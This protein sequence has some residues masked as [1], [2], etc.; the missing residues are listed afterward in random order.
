MS[1]QNRYARVIHNPFSEYADVMER[2]MDRLL[3]WHVFN[4]KFSFQRKLT[5]LMQNNLVIVSLWLERKYKGYRYL[6][7]GNRKRLYVNAEKIVHGFDEFCHTFRVND[8]H[9]AAILKDMGFDMLGDRRERVLYLA[10]IM[11]F[12]APGKR[13]RYL[14]G[15]SFGKLLVDPEKG[16]MTG[17][18]NQIVTF[19]T[20][21]YSLK[22]DV[23]DLKIKLLLGHVCL[24]YEGID[25]EA[26]NGTFQKYGKYEHI[27][28]IVE[29]LTTNLLDVSDFRD[30]QL[31][32]DPR[33]MINAAELAYKISSLRDVVEKNLH[34]S[35][36]NLAVEYAKKNDFDT[37]K[38]FLDKIDDNEL[39]SGIFRNAV[40]YYTNADNFDKAKYYIK[41]AGDTSLADYVIDKEGYYNFEKGN[42]PKAVTLFKK[43]NNAAMIKACY[44]T[45]YNV[46]QRKVSG[47]KNPDS[48]RAYKSDYIR[49]RELSRLMGDYELQGSL[50]DIISKL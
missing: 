22:Y 2:K 9:V 18:C 39:K 25:I 6:G 27:L 50:D 12:L 40:I 33:V 48:A 41:Y 23:S 43:T 44:V 5:A 35:Y 10:M 37:A 20:F 7:K 34:V 24:H 47:A 14:E 16:K 29:L 42:I 15:A 49:M 3:R 8:I 30:E 46:L 28:P 38:F 45:E 19:Y 36:H 17:D 11:A 1:E 21:L 4:D 26:T 31:S 13:F 32:I